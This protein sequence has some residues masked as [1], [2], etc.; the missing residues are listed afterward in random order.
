MP[1]VRLERQS[2][3]ADVL[4]CFYRKEGELIMFRNPPVWGAVLLSSKK[5]AKGRRIFCGG[6]VVVF[7]ARTLEQQSKKKA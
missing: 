4:E 1:N 7:Y 6:G 5:A 3:R 2:V